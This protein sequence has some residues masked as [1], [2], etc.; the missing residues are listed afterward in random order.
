[1]ANWP[2]VR[3]AHWRALLPARAIENLACVVGVNRIGSDATGLA[4]AG[5]SVA[6]DARGEYLADL[7]DRPGCQTVIF[8][9][10]A[11]EAYRA[12][13]PGHLDADDFVL[14]L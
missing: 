6:I 5:D 8:D 4:Y 10:G 9:G 3:G 13:F 2:A 11:L 14:H 1:V 7:R 12:R